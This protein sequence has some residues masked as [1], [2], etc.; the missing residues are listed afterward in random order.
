MIDAYTIGIT[1]AL[2]NGVAAGIAAIRQ[3]LAALDRAI[4]SSTQGFLA[5]RRLSENLGSAT[6]A[7]PPIVPSTHAEASPTIAEPEVPNSSSPPPPT[8]L[9]VSLPLYSA[10]NV[11]APG[12]PLSAPNSL[13]PDVTELRPPSVGR[14]N[15]AAPTGP[16]AP[17]NLRIEAE[18]SPAIPQLAESIAVSSFTSRAV[19]T[20]PAIS[21]QSVKVSPIAPTLAVLPTVMPEPAAPSTRHSMSPQQSLT[22]T[23]MASVAPKVM[24]SQATA[25]TRNDAQN[26]VETPPAAAQTQS[27]PMTGL[28]HGEIILDG[29]RLGRWISDRLARAASRPGS[30]TTAFD[31]RISAL[32]PGAPNGS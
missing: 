29:A 1:L 21:P 23:R 32:Y 5:M 27:K 17:V 25:S 20:A 22:P 9:S 30:G 6:F 28:S 19:S 13:P 26:R 10:P 15:P 2:D 12:A 14:S 31:P 24:T 16:A 8:R 11:T 3:D 7:R 18:P 4:A